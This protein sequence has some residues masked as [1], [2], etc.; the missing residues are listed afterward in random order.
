MKNKAKHK[1]ENKN[2][3]VE[4]TEKREKGDRL[5]HI[6]TEKKYNSVDNFSVGGAVQYLSVMT[7]SMFFPSNGAIFIRLSTIC[8]PLWIKIAFFE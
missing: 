4:E 3:T 1:K 5:I 7:F 2:I 8:P 6:S